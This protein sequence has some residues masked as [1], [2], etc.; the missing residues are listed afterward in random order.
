MKKIMIVLLLLFVLNLSTTIINIP[1]DQP[2]IQ[3]G[4]DVSADGDTVLVAPGTYLENI[5]C[6]GKAISIVSLFHIVMDP[7]YIEQTIIN[8]ISN[9]EYAVKI[10]SGNEL[11]TF[12]SGFTIING[13]NQGGGGIMSFSN[14]EIS[15]S[16]IENCSSSY[17]MGGG[18][19][20]G[21]LTSLIL[22]NLIIRNNVA[23]QSGGGVYIEGVDFV[24]MSN[25]TISNNVVL[26]ETGNSGGI[27]LY[28]INHAILKNVR[29]LNN[30]ILNNE[31]GERTGSYGGIY[32]GCNNLY[33]E[34]LLIQGNYAAFAGGIS[35]YQ[36]S[37]NISNALISGNSADNAGAVNVY[38]SNL[39][40]ANV[41]IIYN[42]NWS[43]NYNIKC[44][45][46]FLNFTNSILNS[47]N[48]NLLL[49][50]GNLSPSTTN[51]QYCNIIGG[52]ET[53]N[54]NQNGVINWLEG[55]IDEDPIF[56]QNGE[57]PYQLTEL[58][59]CI[60]SG[61][62]DTLGLFLPPWDLLHHERVWDGDGNG[63][64]II[65]MGCYE[66]GAD[67]VGVNNHEIPIVDHKMRNYPNPFNPTTTIEFSIQNDSQVKLSI[68]NIKGQK[69]KTI[70]NKDFSKGSH[71]IYWNGDDENRKSV[72]S[73]VYYYKLIVNGKTEAVKKCL[74]LK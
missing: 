55:N 19:G 28:G 29:V 48:Q 64:T 68:F 23:E 4:I 9:G 53:I 56:L 58:S 33:A 70:A 1:V 61:I 54:T 16:I 17:G 34:N 44:M 67:S 36:S 43:E 10:S 63:S 71:S 38:N 46:S 50:S 69:I 41:N 57:S 12:L 40:F 60:D 62:P 47:N 42:S 31:W 45:D 72:S 18:I 49:Y 7:I 25:C 73:G 21:G 52:P 37:G 6:S 8:G 3:A 26:N 59:P 24:E 65:D 32:V 27:K 66:F 30:H 11:F 15:N 13:M 39:N 35:F 51:F 20:C 22:R 14:A 2:T 74:L 5:D